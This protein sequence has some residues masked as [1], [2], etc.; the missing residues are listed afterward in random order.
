MR[1]GSD[2]SATERA[3][4]LGAALLR[5][6]TLLVRARRAEMVYGPEATVDA[7]LARLLRAPSLWDGMTIEESGRDRVDEGSWLAAL[8]QEF[9]LFNF[10]LDV[11]PIALEGVTAPLPVCGVAEWGPR[12]RSVGK[13][14][15]S[16]RP[17]VTVHYRIRP[18]VGFVPDLTSTS[19]CPDDS[20]STRRDRACR[21]C[22]RRSR[23]RSEVFPAFGAYSVES[24]SLFGHGPRASDAFD[25]IQSER[26]LR[27]GFLPSDSKRR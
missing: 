9:G 5:L 23:N 26:R 13:E 14:P 1:D 4:G 3:G 10:D 19:S 24:L 20:G 6:D 2:A 7:W 17:P 15:L 8:G 16:R 18:G 27:C 22:G 12:P 11:I 25:R 21:G